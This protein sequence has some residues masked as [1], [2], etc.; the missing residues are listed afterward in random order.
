MHR[1]LLLFVSLFLLPNCYAQ[2][3]ITTSRTA[4]GKVKT[5]YERGMRMSFNGQLNAAIEDFEKTLQLDPAFIDA[6]IEW[7]NAK[8]QQG[9]WAEAEQGYEKALAIDPAYEPGV[10]YSLGIVEFDQEK[11]D[12]AAAHFE[13]FLKT[14][15]ISEKRK[16]SALKYL[17]NASFAAQALK[18]PV[19]YEP[20]NLGPQI[21]TSEDEYLPTLTADGETLIYTAVRSRQE[22]FY[23]STKKDGQWQ[24]GQPIASVNTEYNEGAQSISADGKLLVFTICEH[25]GG[26]GRCDIYYTEYL[27]GKWTSVKNMGAPINSSAYESLPSVSA[28]G[29]AIYFTSD[30]RGGMGGLDIWASYRQSNGKWGEPQNLGAPVNTPEHDQAPFIHPDGQTL[31]FMSKGH[32][33][34]GEYDLYLSRKQPDGTW[35]KPQNLGYPVNTKGNE[36]AF[37]VNLDGSTAYFASDMPG[38]FG[39]NDLY[40]FELHKSARPLPVTY[41]KATV[42]DVETKQK[43]V[44]TVEFLDLGNGQVHVSSTTDAD[45]VFLITLPAGKDYALNVSK[46]KYLFYSE[47]FALRETASID[48]PFLLDITLTP[49]PS[50]LAGTGDAHKAVPV[51]LKNVFFETGS[52]ELKKESLSELNRLKKLLDDNPSLKIQINGHTDDIGSDADNLTLSENRAR[53]V[54]DFL[55]KQGILVNR[56]KYKGFGEK[57]PVAPND[58]EPGRKQNRRTEFIIID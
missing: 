20:K 39:K 2:K 42:S 54:F 27:N 38:G 14:E 28:D 47:N 36:G 58:S 25:P 41:V 1:F 49:L 12:E 8:N 34:M 21:N 46:D 3:K 40:T 26:L 43:L 4:T 57:S 56:L 31:Y 50:G 16:A 5:T 33:G 9:K 32:P 51:V 35:G 44:A 29:K 18:N 19:S 48:K 55:V 37:T 11:F 23:R 15:K 13:Q 24:K 7:A 30:R 10:F 52:A 6:Q 22:D 53:S 45:G 17:A